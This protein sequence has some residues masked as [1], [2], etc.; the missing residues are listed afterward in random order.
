MIS[1]ARAL[2]MLPAP[3]IGNGQAVYATLLSVR[4]CT[5]PGSRVAMDNPIHPEMLN[6]EFR[7]LFDRVH[8]GSASVGE[9][10][11][12]PTT[13]RLCAPASAL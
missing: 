4:A 8:E 5:A 13:L 7:W 1:D 10:A 2:V 12:P 3:D 9:P 6:G 11:A